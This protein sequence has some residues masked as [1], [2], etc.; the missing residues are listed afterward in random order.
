MVN[1]IV[2]IAAIMILQRYKH[3]DNDSNHSYNQELTDCIGLV[4]E[5]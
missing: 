3:T 4:G 1:I 2:T 5:W